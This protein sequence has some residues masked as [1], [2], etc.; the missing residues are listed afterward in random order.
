MTL[1]LAVIERI[2]RNAGADR[3]TEGAVRAMQESAQSIADE[4]VK[5]AAAAAR[6]DGRDE[7][8]VGDVEAALET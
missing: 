1:P 4:V 3:V 6:R 2:M 8:T 5:D 7:V